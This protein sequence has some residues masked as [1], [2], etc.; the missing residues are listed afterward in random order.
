MVIKRVAHKEILETGEK[1]ELY[2]VFCKCDKCLY[3]WVHRG[4]TKTQLPVRCARV[5]GCPSPFY[6]NKGI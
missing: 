2:A 3:T 6:W 1:V 5:K 4:K